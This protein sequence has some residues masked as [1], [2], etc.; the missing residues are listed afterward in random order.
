M[1]EPAENVHCRS[2]MK[3]VAQLTKNPDLHVIVVRFQKAI[4]TLPFKV[5]FKVF[6]IRIRAFIFL[7]VNKLGET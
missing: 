7:R 2:V 4:L 6:V 5:I 3:T 1:R